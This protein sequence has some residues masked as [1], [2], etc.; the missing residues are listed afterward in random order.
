MSLS[1]SERFELE[2]QLQTSG[3]PSLT[4]IDAEFARRHLMDFVPWCS[5]GFVRPEHLAPFVSRLERAIRGEP[6]RVAVHAPPQHGKT[7][8]ALHGIAWALRQ[9]PKLQGAYATYGDRL[10]RKKSRRARNLAE[11]IGV[12]LGAEAL[13][14]WETS[15]G[16]GLLATGVCGPL[17]GFSK[18]DLLII[19]DP[20]KNRQ[21]AESSARR[22]AIE[23]WWDDVAD[24]RLWPNSSA[25][26]FMTRWHP[27]DL[28]GYLIKQHGFEYVKLPALDEDDNALWETGSWPASR[29]KEKRQRSPY[30][31]ASR[32][33]GEPRARGETVFDA[34][35]TFTELPKVYRA[36]FGVDLA[37]SAKTSS[38]WSVAVKMLKAQGKYYV[39]H[40]ERRQERVARFKRRCR[41]LHRGE[42][43]APWLW[44]TSTTEQ[45]TADLFQE[46][47]RSVPLEPRIAR[48]DKLVRAQRYAEAWN[49]GEVLVPKN[50][51]WLKQFLEE[52][53]DFTGVG[54]ESD[55][56]IDAAVAAFDL[57]DEPVEEI[58]L[59]PPRA[60]PQGLYAD[61][62]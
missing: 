30:A 50:A 25:I 21:E 38:D 54:D 7:D 55:D 56:T 1:P 8:A 18:V 29:L 62:V 33:Q 2:Q 49:A 57:L 4:E 15:A 22:Q 28:A 51:P 14:D 46:G 20:Y 9:N 52:H 39:T 36:A 17:T 58:P 3:L 40:V 60:V 31:F 37:Y 43:A 23:E 32:F 35:T 47:P 42:K 44:Y 12:Q 45:G 10:A 19:D 16:G 34:A 13:N 59:E 11:R 41:V 26:V 24:T 27:S 6:Q 53:Q 48:A 61:G 5:P